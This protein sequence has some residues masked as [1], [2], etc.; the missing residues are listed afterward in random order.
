MTLTSIGRNKGYQGA[1][2]YLGVSSSRYPSIALELP[3]Y[4]LP[5][6][7]REGASSHP[8]WLCDR[9][10]GPVHREECGR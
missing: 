10:V 2:R 6:Y 1:P 3:R 4:P 9:R 8:P 5:E 7:A